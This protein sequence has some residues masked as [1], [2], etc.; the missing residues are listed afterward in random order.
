MHISN[1][2]PRQQTARI[3]AS[4]VVERHTAP[5]DARSAVALAFADFWTHRHGS[6]R[7]APAVIIRRALQLLAD[8]LGTLEADDILHEVRAFRVAGKGE[9]SA[10]TLTQARARIEDHQD[11]PGRQ[12]MNDWRDALQSVEDRRESRAM[13]DRL[14]AL[15]GT[16]GAQ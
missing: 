14:E 13:L 10:L 4:S 15:M 1:T 9:G 3:S 5:L 12:P 8:H 11:A 6:I 16:E 7:P 2:P